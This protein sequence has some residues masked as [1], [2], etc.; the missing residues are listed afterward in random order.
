[1]FL[2]GLL[3]PPAFCGRS[4]FI[5]FAKEELHHIGQVAW[6]KNESGRPFLPRTFAACVGLEAARGGSFAV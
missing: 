5:A 4:L 3:R 2:E 1:M 6:S